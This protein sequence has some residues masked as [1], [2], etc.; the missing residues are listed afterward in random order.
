MPLPDLSGVLKH[1]HGYIL[2]NMDIFIRIY[3]L[4][5]IERESRERERERERKTTCS[6]AAQHCL[7]FL[8]SIV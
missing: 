7:R 8:S 6:T 4:K 3:T 5:E 2:K 1:S